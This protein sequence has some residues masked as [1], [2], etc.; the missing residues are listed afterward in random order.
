MLWMFKI[1]E[2]I[3]DITENPL[4]SLLFVSSDIIIVVADILQA[5]FE[6]V[7]L[8]HSLGNILVISAPKSCIAVSYDIASS[9]ILLA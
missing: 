9:D 1:V 6:V 8:L 3:K 5:Q 4:Y 7:I 2:F